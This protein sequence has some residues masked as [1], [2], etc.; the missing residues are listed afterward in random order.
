MGLNPD[1]DTPITKLEDFIT[2]RAAPSG[3]DVT[4]D[5]S[6]GDGDDDKQIVLKNV[7]INDLEGMIILV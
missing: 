4:I 6:L 5:L 3:G 7:D 1:D 2:Y